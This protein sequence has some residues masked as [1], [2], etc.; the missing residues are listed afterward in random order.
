[1]ATVMLAAVRDFLQ[2]HAKAQRH[3][4]S[5]EQKFREALALDMKRM[6]QREPVAS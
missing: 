3:H 1:M 5:L 6:R 2:V 4:G